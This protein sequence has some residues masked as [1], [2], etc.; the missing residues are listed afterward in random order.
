MAQPPGGL[1]SVRVRTVGLKGV[2]GAWS[3]PAQIRAPQSCTHSAE[4][5]APSCMLQ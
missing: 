2:M 1:L 5:A 3:D 4:V